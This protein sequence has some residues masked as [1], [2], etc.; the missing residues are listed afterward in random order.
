MQTVMSAPLFEAIAPET[1]GMPLYRVVK[2]SLL[3]AIESGSCAPGETLPS[4][5]EIAGAMGV[6]IGTLRRAV[7]EQEANAADP[8]GQP[9]HTQVKSFDRRT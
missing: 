7:D 6:S 1:A 2:R 9:A 5:T 3:T 8:V 4:E